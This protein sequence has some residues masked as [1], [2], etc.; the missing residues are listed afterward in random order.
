M[1]VKAEL[2]KFPDRQTS[3]G[4]LIDSY[5]N[6]KEELDDAAV[7]LLYSANRWEKRQALCITCVLSPPNTSACIR[8][9]PNKGL[10]QRENAGILTAR[11]NPCCGPI[12]LFRYCVYFCQEDSWIRPDLVQGKHVLHADVSGLSMLAFIPAT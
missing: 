10:M 2:W 12:L 7:H 8:P 9:E 3:T 11:H 6:N 5:L 1:Q 4:R